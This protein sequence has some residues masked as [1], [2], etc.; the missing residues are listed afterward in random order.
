MVQPLVLGT[1]QTHY[2]KMVLSLQSHLLI[3]MAIITEVCQKSLIGVTM[4]LFRIHLIIKPSLSCNGNPAV[5]VVA[6]ENNK[7]G[8]K[9]LDAAHSRALS[10][11]SVA[12]A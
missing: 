4:R 5:W 11:P 9:M 6:E 10:F 3:H 8:F 7:F 12:P 1:V 2:K